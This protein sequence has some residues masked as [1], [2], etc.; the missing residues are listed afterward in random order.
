MPDPY[1]GLA[2][3]STVGIIPVTH[4]TVALQWPVDPLKMAMGQTCQSPT[5]VVR[6][7]YAI[8]LSALAP[9]PETAPLPLLSVGGRMILGQLSQAEWQ[10]SR[11]NGDRIWQNWHGKYHIFHQFQEEL[12]VVEGKTYLDDTRACNPSA[13]RS[14]FG[15]KVCRTVLWRETEITLRIEKMSWTKANFVQCLFGSIE[16][17]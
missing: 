9:A 3:G 7:H 6:Y 15:L 11:Q 17:V 8:S 5:V 10:N 16:T 12:R 2:N 14:K 13:D 1:H 4:H